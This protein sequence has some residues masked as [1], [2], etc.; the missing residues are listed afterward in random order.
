MGVVALSLTACSV[1]PEGCADISREAMPILDQ[2]NNTDMLTNPEGMKDV[3]DAAIAVFDEYP[4]LLPV[5][6]KALAAF[7]DAIPADIYSATMEDVVLLQ[8]ASEDLDLASEE[9][10]RVCGL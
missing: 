10:T 5:G 3:L 9:F 8:A 7:R 4:D 6:R 2:I 1:A